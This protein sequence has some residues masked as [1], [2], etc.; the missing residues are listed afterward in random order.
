MHSFVGKAVA[1]YENGVTLDLRRLGKPTDNV[2]VESFNAR[3]RN[4]A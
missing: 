1:G 2:F 4:E 3:L